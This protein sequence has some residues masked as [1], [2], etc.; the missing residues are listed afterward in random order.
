MLWEVLTLHNE[1]GKKS[2]VTNESK[3]RM[4]ASLSTGLA[5]FS[6]AVPG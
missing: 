2:N 4:P 6:F 5:G 3:L 1:G